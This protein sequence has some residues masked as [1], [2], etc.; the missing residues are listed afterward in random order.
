MAQMQELE[1]INRRQSV[2]LADCFRANEERAREIAKAAE[3]QAKMAAH[4][5]DDQAKMAALEERLAKMAA[6]AS[7]D[8]AKMAAL[9]DRLANMASRVRGEEEQAKME[10][11]YK[12]ELGRLAT[13]VRCA[14]AI[15]EESQSHSSRLEGEK[16]ELSNKLAQLRQ[17][18]EGTQGELAQLRQLYEGAQFELAQHRQKD[19]PKSEL[20][21][22]RKQYL[23]AQGELALLRLKYRTELGTL[24]TTLAEKEREC[25]EMKSKVLG[26]RG[27][28]W[29]GGE[30][31]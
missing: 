3:D 12:A 25:G 16:A 31:V 17:L 21:N 6:R 14:R 28:G 20:T 4:A 2:V 5:S 18:H 23:E 13:E 1:D 24:N 15:L 30:V 27:E 7:D 9:E 22:L 8:Q 19:V 11:G 10:E 26:K 29:G